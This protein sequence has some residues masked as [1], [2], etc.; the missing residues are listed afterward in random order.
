MY[1]I[2]NSLQINDVSTYESISQLS[3]SQINSLSYDREKMTYQKYVNAISSIYDNIEAECLDESNYKFI[4]VTS[5]IDEEEEEEVVEENKEEGENKEA[6]EEIN[7]N[8]PIDFHMVQ[9]RDISNNVYIFYIPSNEFDKWLN[10]LVHLVPVESLDLETC[11]E[12][13]YLYLLY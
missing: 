11:K 12:F 4:F 2:L 7:I 3:L 13:V 5:N 10:Q 6:E 1:I 8:D 9:L